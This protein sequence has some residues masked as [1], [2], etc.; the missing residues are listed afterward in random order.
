MKTIC[1]VGGDARM[2]YAARSL[3]AAGHTVTRI[4]PSEIAQAREQG[5]VIVGGGL[6]EGCGGLDWITYRTRRFYTTTRV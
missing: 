4:P 5:S 6:P 2:E 3:E 1:L